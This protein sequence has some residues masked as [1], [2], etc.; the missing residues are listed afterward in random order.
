MAYISF[1]VVYTMHMRG[2]N[3]GPF[4]CSKRFV[5]FVV[6]ICI[7]FVGLVVVCVLFVDLICMCVLF[8]VC[9]CVLFVGH[10][11]HVGFV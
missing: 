5:V 7:L 4:V 2:Y 9:M 6:C 8:V 3:V 11:M 1:F 10:S